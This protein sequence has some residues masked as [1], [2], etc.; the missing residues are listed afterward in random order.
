MMTKRGKGTDENNQKVNPTII[1]ALLTNPTRIRPKNFCL[2]IKTL[3]I[4][5]RM[6]VLKLIEIRQHSK[7]FNGIQVNSSDC[8]WN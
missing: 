8:K 6:I 5:Q 4:T 7:T 1:V 3:R 2:L